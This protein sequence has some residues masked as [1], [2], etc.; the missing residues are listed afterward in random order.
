M[1]DHTCVR[2]WVLSV[3]MT[4]NAGMNDYIQWSEQLA[5]DKVAQLRFANGK[6]LRRIER[7]CEKEN[8]KVDAFW[9]ARER[10]QQREKAKRAARKLGQQRMKQVGV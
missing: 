7:Q 1:C 8:K 3:G 4:R 2:V 5:L 6:E 10:K 9:A